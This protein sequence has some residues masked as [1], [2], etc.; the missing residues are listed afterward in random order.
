MPAQIG[1]GYPMAN[2]NGD[3]VKMYYTTADGPTTPADVVPVL[4][5]FNSISEMLATPGFTWA[6]RGGSTS[7]A[8]MS[9]YGYTQS[10]VRGYGVLEVSLARTSDG[11]W[12]GLNDQTTNRTSGGTYG[13][14]SSQTWAQVQA[15]QIVVG[16]QGA[17]QPYMRWDEI[18][19]AYGNTHIL[20]VDPKYT[21]G[22]H[23]TE[24][25]TLV[26][27]SVGTSRAIIKYSGSGSIAVDLSNA[28]KAMGF[29]TC[30]LFLASEASATQGGN[31]S[32][33]TYGPSWTLIGMEHGASQAIWNEAIALGKPVIG[34]TAPTQAAYN[35]TMSKGAKGVLVSATAIV[36]PVSWWAPSPIAA[37]NFS[38][39]TG[40]VASD[41]LGLRNLTV[42]SQNWSTG[43]IGSG[44]SSAG[45]SVAIPDKA[46]LETP[47]RTLMFWANWAG[48]SGTWRWG[49][50]FRLVGLSTSC[51][52]IM[53]IN[54]AG[55]LYCRIRIGGVNTNITIPNNGNDGTWHHYA[56]T[57]DGK[58]FIAYRDGIVVGSTPITG[59]INT[60][61]E[62]QMH[63]PGGTNTLDDVRMFSKALT[64]AQIVQKMNT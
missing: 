7:Y 18:V 37:W 31:G 3:A 50:D 21:L 2:G 40:T 45:G 5:G 36:E 64:Q 55:D 10:V 30:G 35:T 22:S 26:A 6:E 57:Y 39:G 25:L 43:Y 42:T 20:V 17:P 19:A 1:E 38:E 48:N 56:I 61:D 52:G 13:D 44:L 59:T 11:V 15:Q 62:I 41:L 46:G 34:H 14:A 49:I 23:R 51:W 27:N 24:F 33:Q 16:G 4:R 63:D 60:C 8:E 28:A 32:L 29:E 12:F 47:H 53:P 9:L 54:G 58:N